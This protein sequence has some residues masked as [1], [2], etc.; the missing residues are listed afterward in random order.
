MVSLRQSN[1]Q[2]AVQLENVSERLHQAHA[3]STKAQRTIVHLETQ[4][5]WLQDQLSAVHGREAQAQSLSQGGQPE[6]SL[7]GAVSAYP[8]TT[9]GL[10]SPP[11][12]SLP[13]PQEDYFPEK[14]IEGISGMLGGLQ[15]L[16]IEVEG[17]LNASNNIREEENEDPAS[18]ISLSHT[19]SEASLPLH[20]QEDDLSVS[21]GPLLVENFSFATSLSLSS[22][23]KP[24]QE[25]QRR[26]S[27]TGT[28]SGRSNLGPGGRA[29]Y[30]SSPQFQEI[31]EAYTNVL[32][33]QSAEEDPVSKWVRTVMSSASAIETDPKKIE[34]I[35]LGLQEL[36][37]E[38][39]LPLPLRRIGP[40]QYLL[41][42]GH[43]CKL[44]VRLISGRLM[45]RQGTAWV[46]VFTWLERQPL[47][48]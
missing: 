1:K 7:S 44:G 8:V 15:A 39:G 18:S 17:S 16:S 30:G 4:L 32:T 10:S 12:S 19:L 38:N 42:P 48:L 37:E 33:S 28:A 41:G 5:V 9:S 40:C 2:L 43:R 45:A 27:S 13:A 3:N 14:G 35:L 23:S 21:C 26:R 20:A 31:R 22:H 6:R 36:C 46:D 47:E 25:Q 34:P 11:T 29:T 24:L